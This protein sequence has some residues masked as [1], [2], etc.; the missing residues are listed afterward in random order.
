MVAKA[1][2]AQ[3]TEPPGIAQDAP[4]S[5]F[6][7]RHCWV[8]LVPVANRALIARA[9]LCDAHVGPYTAIGRD[10]LVEGAEIDQSVIVP[11]ASICHL[12]SRLEASVVG[13]RA[14]IFGAFRLPK[15]PRLNIGEGAEVS[16][17]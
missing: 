2:V 12:G 8:A 5:E 3:S 11:G 6:G 15:A 4:R 7:R 17:A 1:V 13:P 9:R 10:V 14:R 16:L